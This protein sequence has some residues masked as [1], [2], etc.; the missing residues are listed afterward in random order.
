[1]LIDQHPEWVYWSIT[2]VVLYS[3]SL[4]L[5]FQLGAFFPWCDERR[6]IRRQLLEILM[7]TVG[8]F[9]PA[10]VYGVLASNLIVAFVIL[11]IAWAPLATAFR[12]GRRS[13]DRARESWRFDQFMSGGR[14][15][16]P[17]PSRRHP[18]RP[19][20]SKW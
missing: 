5:S 6:I 4:I 2:L 19:F 9:T 17:Q 11:A 13:F 12:F 10:I 3:G 16:F 8:V 1:M 15:N 20:G 18:D 7:V 14:R